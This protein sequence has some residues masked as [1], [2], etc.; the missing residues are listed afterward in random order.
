MA[1]LMSVWRRAS[2]WAAATT[3]L[4]AYAAVRAARSVAIARSAACNAGLLTAG[5]DPDGTGVGVEEEFEP[6]SPAVAPELPPN[7]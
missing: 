3:L 1:A 6:L 7:S 4:A 5:A 2:A